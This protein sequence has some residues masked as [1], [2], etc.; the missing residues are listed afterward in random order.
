MRRNCRLFGQT[1]CKSRQLD[2]RYLVTEVFLAVDGVLV[3]STVSDVMED[4]QSNQ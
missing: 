3:A 1:K 4:E 2:N